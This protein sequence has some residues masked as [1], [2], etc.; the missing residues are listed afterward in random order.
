MN[1]KRIFLA[2]IV[3][4]M[5]ASVSTSQS[6]VKHSKWEKLAR[7]SQNHSSANQSESAVTI[8][9][10]AATDDSQ[11][12]LD[13]TSIIA[14]DTPKTRLEGTWIITQSMGRDFS[15]TSFYTF[16]AGKDANEGV[17]AFSDQFLFVPNP[18]CLPG[19]G[20]WKRTADRSY[21]GTHESVCYDT[22]NGFAPAGFLKF[23]Y[24]LTLNDPGTALTGRAHLE[25]FDPD[26]NPV[27]FSADLTLR[28]V[29]MQA[30]APPQ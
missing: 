2:L 16:G 27:P 6:N 25:A 22:D 7:L 19:Q 14:A 18:S 4:A 21:I 17:A 24:S 29:R 26:G 28:G 8:D 9:R 12:P 13:Q 3:T 10:A 15:E 1:R 20:V 23:R 5:L 11:T 30:Q